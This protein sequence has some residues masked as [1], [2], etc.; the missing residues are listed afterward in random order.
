MK[1][2]LVIY[3]ITLQLLH[4]EIP[5]IYEENIFSFLSVYAYIEYMTRLD[6][7][8]LHPK[9]EVPRT[10]T[11]YNLSNRFHAGCRFLN[12]IY[13]FSKQRQTSKLYLCLSITA[14]SLTFILPSPS[15]SLLFGPFQS[16]IGISNKY[17]GFL[18][19]LSSD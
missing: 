1:G 15:G 14:A 4:S 18:F 17:P 13:L 5:F 10:A 2:P 9:L 3:G 8:Q 7:S 6:Q 19:F 11:N 16:M 12:M